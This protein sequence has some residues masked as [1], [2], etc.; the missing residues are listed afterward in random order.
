MEVPHRYRCRLGNDIRPSGR[1]GA[2]F[3]PLIALG[4]R[5]MKNLVHRRTRSAVAVR[6]LGWLAISGTLALALVGPAAGSVLATGG[7]VVDG[8]R[9][10]WNKATTWVA[11]LQKDGDGPVEA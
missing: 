11:D 9:S 2:R 5:H 7:I 10:E 8:N 4:D 1:S 3:H 6:G